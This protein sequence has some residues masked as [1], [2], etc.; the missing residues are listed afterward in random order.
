MCA[1]LGYFFKRIFSSPFWSKTWPKKVLPSL[2]VLCKGNLVVLLHTITMAV[3]QHYANKEWQTP[4]QCWSNPKQ[5]LVALGLFFNRQ[6][7]SCILVS[8]GTKSTKVDSERDDSPNKSNCKM[9]Q[10][11][12]NHPRSCCIAFFFSYRKRYILSYQIVCCQQ[13]TM[14]FF[15]CF[16]TDKP[17]SAPIS[18]PPSECLCGSSA[19]RHILTVVALLPLS[20]K[21]FHSS[22]EI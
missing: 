18:S 16:K 20:K 14:F 21:F 13:I 9:W 6:I 7:G 12:S 11:W 2:G 3:V 8:R 22:L 19:A 17:N 10:C 5:H 1:T 15:S 4:P